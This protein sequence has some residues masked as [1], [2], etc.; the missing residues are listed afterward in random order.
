MSEVELK[1]LFQIEDILSLPNAI[2]KIIFDND[3]RLHHIYREL[4]QLNTHDLSRD[5]FQDI[6]EGELAQRNQNKQDFTPNVVGILLSRLTGV[7]KG[8][9][10]EP[11]AGNGS[12]IISNW[13]HRVK[14]LGT[15]FKPSEHPV[16]CWELSDR[17]IP[18]LLLN[19]SIITS[20]YQ[21]S[22]NRIWAVAM[23][24]GLNLFHPVNKTFAHYSHSADGLLDNNITAI[25]ELPSGRLLLG[26]SAG[27]S[28]LDPEKGQFTNYDYKRGFPLT[29]VNDGS[30][31]V[32]QNQ[33][34]YVGGVT[35]LVIFKEKD[36]LQTPIKPSK[37][38]FN[39]LYVN[40]IE[41]NCK[42]NS[43]IQY[44]EIDTRIEL[45]CLFPFQFRIG[46]SR[47]SHA[48]RRSLVTKRIIIFYSG[49]QRSHIIIIAYTI[50][51]CHTITRSQFQRRNLR[52][53]P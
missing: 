25:T 37:I 16:E 18:L 42:G 22:K 33:D 14:T 26:T 47:S 13:W 10:Y 34:I 3:E 17:S 15:D 35:G 6:Y 43:V 8:V 1:K 27:L 5:W 36:L 38:W 41:V 19:L 23:D 30:L 28:I 39:N 45:F 46:Q 2:F 50:I 44:R 52:Y 7:S 21:D 4:L 24:R 48:Q 12:L 53:I 20:L 51:S 11:T 32:S 49:V 40:N 9:I 31:L 29:M